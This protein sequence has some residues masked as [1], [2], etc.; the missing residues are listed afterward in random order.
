MLA[1]IGANGAVLPKTGAFAPCGAA[2]ANPDT[3]NSLISGSDTRRLGS[4][5]GLARQ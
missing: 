3:Y 4:C 2:Q 5:Q 1:Y